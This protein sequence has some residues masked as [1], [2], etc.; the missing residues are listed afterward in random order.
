MSNRCENRLVIT[1]AETRLIQFLEQL[2]QPKQPALAWLMDI[3]QHEAQFLHP[4]PKLDA[5]CRVAPTEA[6]NIWVWYTY[7]TQPDTSEAVPDFPEHPVERL[8]FNFDTPWQPDVLPINCLAKS[9][10]D[11]QFELGFWEPNHGFRGMLY[12]QTGQPL[13][14]HYD[15]SWYAWDD[16]IPWDDF[17]L[18]PLKPIA[19]LPIN[20]ETPCHDP[21]LDSD[22]DVSAELAV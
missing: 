6:A 7:Y 12:W 11:L 4:R 13:N 17:S 5:P 22:Q 14:Y 21:S 1:G 16:V 9:W 2:R 10:L 15:P 8:S 18:I 19:K 20:F 3:L